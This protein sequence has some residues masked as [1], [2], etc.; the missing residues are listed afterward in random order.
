MATVRALATQV[1]PCFFRSVSEGYHEGIHKALEVE[2]AGVRPGSSLQDVSVG[3]QPTGSLNS[4]I[5]ARKKKT[6]L[7][8]LGRW[9]MALRKPIFLANSLAL[10]WF[11]M[12]LAFQGRSDN[13]AV[14]QA[15]TKAAL[16]NGA[17]RRRGLICSSHAKLSTGQ[18]M[19]WNINVPEVRATWN[20][21]C[22]VCQDLFPV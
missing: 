15:Q 7:E 16:I 11:P 21:H 9:R 20:R 2:Q 19:V 22:L 1:T 18:A 17:T 12:C 14:S 5:S 3:K 6:C 13:A 10:F 4:V 8:F